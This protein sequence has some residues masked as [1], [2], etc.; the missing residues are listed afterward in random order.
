MATIT[1]AEHLITVQT[2]ARGEGNVIP[3][4][5]LNGLDVEWKEM[6]T[7]HGKNMEGAHLVTIEEFRRCPERYSFTYP[8]WT[9]EF[10]P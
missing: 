10:C 5:Y 9:G 7:N 1:K 8:T 4:K 3:E 2:S 6:W